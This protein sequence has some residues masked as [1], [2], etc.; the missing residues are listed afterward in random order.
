MIKDRR[1]GV[2]MGGL[3]A[4]REISLES[5]RAVLE[6][7][8]RLGYRA[9]GIVV[10]HDVTD[11]LR[12]AAPD[13]VFNALHGRYG[14]DG[15]IQGMLELLGIPYTGSGVLASALAMDKVKAKEIFRLHNLPSPPHYL[16]HGWQRPT[17]S[18]A[19]GSFG[20]PVVVKPAGEGSSIGVSLVSDE[21]ALVRACDR[22]FELDDTVVVER[23]ISGSEISVGV[24]DGRA[25]GA[26][27]IVSHNEI[28]DYD[29]KYTAGHAHYHVPA[30]LSPEQHSVVNAQALRAHHALGCTGATRVD[31]IVSDLG[32]EYIL[33]VNT[34]PGL[35]RRSLLPRLA[36]HAGLSYDQLVE[37]V[38]LGAKLHIGTHTEAGAE[39]P[40]TGES[41]GRGRH[42]RALG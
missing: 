10:E 37:R 23:Y 42:R 9:A 27:S 2:L 15:C 38:L 5:G 16:L 3:S 4:E 30:R 29:A 28:F 6:A 40:R 31:M 13:V 1:V 12:R 41:Q 19:H 11:A 7:L 26:L 25:L 17:I 22:A 39:A 8:Q 20:Y 32:N 33:E 18:D 21:R 24:L 35:T 36:E 34:S 14:E